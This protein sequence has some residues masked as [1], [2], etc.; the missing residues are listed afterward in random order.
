MLV[1]Y[2]STLQKQLL[3]CNIIL[4]NFGRYLIF[5]IVQQSKH[6]HILQ[7][8]SCVALPSLL[9]DCSH[10][11]DFR[12]IGLNPLRKEQVYVADHP[13]LFGKDEEGV[14]RWVL[15]PGLVVAEL[16]LE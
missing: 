11:V 7:Y 8:L 10:D 3:G 2:I 4:L 9:L 15:Q 5:L 6:L 16:L 14:L 13:A 1:E 12:L